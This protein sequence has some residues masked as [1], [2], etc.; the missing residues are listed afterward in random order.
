MRPDDHH[1]EPFFAGLGHETER[2]THEAREPGGSGGGVDPAGPQ[3]RS[4][5]PSVKWKL[6][7]VAIGLA[8]LAWLIAEQAF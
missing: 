1:V 2:L 4:A 8:A 6:L 3:T 5:D 7:A